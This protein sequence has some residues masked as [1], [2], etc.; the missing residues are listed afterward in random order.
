MEENFTPL[1]AELRGKK[2]FILIKIGINLVEVGVN[3]F[4]AIKLYYN[5]AI[6]SHPKF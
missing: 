1:L 3:W 5:S 2:M 6:Q 4:L